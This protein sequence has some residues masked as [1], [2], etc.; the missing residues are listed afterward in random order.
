MER[1]VQDYYED[2]TE[3]FATKG[4][5]IF[6]DQHAGELD[7]LRDNAYLDCDSNDAWQERRGEIKKLITIVF[8]ENLIR[9][10]YD[11]VVSQEKIVQQEELH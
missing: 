11:N 10:N 2:L 7:R 4:W 3:M 8:Y 9:N 6:V 1:D 5:Q